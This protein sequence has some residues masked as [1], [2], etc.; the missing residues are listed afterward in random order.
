MLRFVYDYELITPGV[1]VVDAWQETNLIPSAGLAYLANAMFGDT[2]PIGTFYMGLFNNN[3]V[4][5]QGNTSADIP[6]TINEFTAY[7]ETTRPLW[8]RVFDGVGA[9]SNAASRGTFTCNAATRIYGGFLVSTSAK[10][11]SSGL[12]LSV[13]RFATPKDVEIGQVIRARATINLIPTEVI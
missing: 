2:A 13:T 1:G 8:N 10:G 9:I 12:L 6:A 3:F 11:G 7:D 5:S 4:P